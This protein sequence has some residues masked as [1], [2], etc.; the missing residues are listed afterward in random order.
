MIAVLIIAALAGAFVAASAAVGAALASLA[1]GEA[2]ADATWPRI[3]GALCG[4]LAIVWYG[5]APLTCW[6][7]RHVPG[8][9]GAWLIGSLGELAP[10]APANG[11][12]GS[13]APKML[14]DVLRVHMERYGRVFKFAFGRRKPTLIVID[15]DVVQD[16]GM[17]KF[18]KVRPTAGT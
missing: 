16:I 5:S 7:Y 14:V 6:R 3:G 1:H 10:D 11:K 12:A 9:R 15:P 17:R 13:G 2:A 8:A 18:F 4:I